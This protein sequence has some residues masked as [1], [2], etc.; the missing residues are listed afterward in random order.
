MA[1]RLTKKKK[2]KKIKPK[3]LRVEY[4][5]LN[6]CIGKN[7]LLLYISFA[8]GVQNIWHNRDLIS[9]ASCKGFI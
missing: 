5:C 2:E 9:L 1:T 7:K 8:C 4:P 3:I 6:A